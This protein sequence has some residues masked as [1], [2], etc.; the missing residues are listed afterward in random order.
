[1]ALN[2]E[3]FKARLTCEQVMLPYPLFEPLALK[4]QVVYQV[5]AFR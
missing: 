4:G 5:G 2:L 1:M 3:V